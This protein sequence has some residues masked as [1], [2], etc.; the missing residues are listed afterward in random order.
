MG[1][2][3]APPHNN[4]S[5][6]Q[7]RE[8]DKKRPVFVVFDY[9]GGGRGGGG[10]AKILRSFFISYYFFGVFWND[11]R[12][13]KYALELRGYVKYMFFF[14]HFTVHYSQELKV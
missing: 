6:Y 12:P 3:G 2:I 7:L 9:E 4:S 1:I 13:P 10:N 14:L 11:P 5:L 8:G